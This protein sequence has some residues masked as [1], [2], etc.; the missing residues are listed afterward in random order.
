VIFEKGL[1]YLPLAKEGLEALERWARDLPQDP[2]RKLLLASVPAL[3]PY[4]LAA[5]AGSTFRPHKARSS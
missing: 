3:E 2:K 5:D 4:L 1:N